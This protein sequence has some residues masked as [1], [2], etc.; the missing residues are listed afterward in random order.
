MHASFKCECVACCRAR[1][2]PNAS[3]RRSLTIS[4]TVD[5]EKVCDGETDKPRV[6]RPFAWTPR[7]V[8]PDSSDYPGTLN[9]LT[10]PPRVVRMAGV[11][12]DF[13][14]AVS[15]VGTR[16]SDEE[17]MQFARELAR[18]L[19][20]RS[21]VIVS[22]GA[23]GIDRAAHEGALDVGGVT[24]AVLAGGLHQ[25][26]PKSNIRLFERIAERG[27]LISEKEDDEPPL[28][29]YFLARNRI[30]AAL[31]QLTVVVQAPCR[32]GAMS[33]AA[34]AKALSKPVF[35]VPW[36]P[37]EPR[38][39]GCSLLIKAGAR[40]CTSVRDVLSVAPLGG[41]RL[42]ADAPNQTEKPSDFLDVGEDEKLVW[43]VL[44]RKAL[45]LDDISLKTGL[46][47]ARVQNSI[48]MLLLKGL[49]VDRGG[50]RYCRAS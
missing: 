22:G 38:G 44:G 41:R 45:H 28:K 20:R 47:V 32:S 21:C 4:T 29:P 3:T 1:S 11:A 17:G 18:E 26:F 5:F 49:L 14:S 31:G 7:H 19:A 9:V 16:R 24:I 30:I 10:D 37:Y 8:A 2:I 42:L 48:L 34:H 13:H 43:S 39:A 23:E 36:G 40:I 15:I 27:L 50:G 25:P 33:T 6:T 12:P 35:A 46:P